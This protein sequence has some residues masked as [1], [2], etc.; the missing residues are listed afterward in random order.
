M[1]RRKAYI[2]DDLH[3]F[4]KSVSSLNRIGCDKD[5]LPVDRSTSSGNLKEEVSTHIVKFVTGNLQ[6]YWC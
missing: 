2:P 6:A 3:I 1:L 4:V 5:I